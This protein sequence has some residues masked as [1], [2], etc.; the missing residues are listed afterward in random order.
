MWKDKVR[1]LKISDIKKYRSEIVDFLQQD[2]EKTYGRR[3][4][5]DYIANKMLSLEKN[6]ENGTAII[7]GAFYDTE[8]VGFLW[9]YFLEGFFDKFFHIAYIAVSETK[10]RRGIGKA[11][12]EAA[13]LLVEKAENTEFIE[14]I[15]GVNNQDAIGFYRSQGFLADREILRK[16]VGIEP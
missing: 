9:G 15:V 11:L 7:F 3:A 5:E 12:L 14:L 16:K 4:N 8:I 6:L 13:Y 2:Y 1:E 10:R